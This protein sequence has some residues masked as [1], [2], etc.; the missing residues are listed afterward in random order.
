MNKNNFIILKKFI[1]II[2]IFFGVALTIW[3]LVESTAIYMGGGMYIRPFERL[4]IYIFLI[5]FGITTFFNKYVKE[6][7][8]NVVKNAIYLT[9]IGLLSGITVTVIAGFIPIG[10]AHMEITYADYTSGW[11]L[12]WLVLYYPY[13]CYFDMGRI[14]ITNLLIDVVIW[15]VLSIQFVFLI[16]GTSVRKIQV[17]RNKFKVISSKSKK[18]LFFFIPLILAFILISSTLILLNSNN[19]M[20]KEREINFWLGELNS[21]NIDEVNDYESGNYY[22]SSFIQVVEHYKE[23]L[24]QLGVTVTWD[25]AQEKYVLD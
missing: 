8:Q 11:P 15:S 19:D 13:E 5:I 20:Q 3:W 17:L 6:D 18:I 24:K 10:I 25:S 4:L 12:P 23:E 16:T 14:L 21:L 22:D 9:F 7:T 2:S 1:A